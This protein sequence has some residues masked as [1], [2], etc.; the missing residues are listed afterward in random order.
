MECNASRTLDAFSNEGAAAAAAEAGA[1]DN[2]VHAASQVQIGIWKSWSWGSWG[3]GEGN[4]ATDDDRGVDLDGRAGQEAL[5]HYRNPPD[6]DC[7]VRTE[8]EEE[9]QQCE[10]QIGGKKIAAAAAVAG[11]AAADQ[12]N[13]LPD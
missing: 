9:G 4:A 3:G 12:P 11:V 7:Q 1:A 8:E 5:D 10:A 6:Y 13:P 2:V